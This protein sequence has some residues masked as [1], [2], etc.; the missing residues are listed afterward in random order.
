MS[1]PFILESDRTCSNG[2]LTLSST[3]A[4]IVKSVGQAAPPRCD[5]LRADV[6]SIQSALNRFAPTDGGPLVLLKEDGIFGP[7]TNAAIFRFQQV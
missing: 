4:F 5:N 2:T 1:K 7:K 3:T 6:K